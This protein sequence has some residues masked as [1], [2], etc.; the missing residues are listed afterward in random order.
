MRSY[1]VLFLALL[2]AGCGGG[3]GGSS[4]TTGSPMGDAPVSQA[5]APQDAAASSTRSFIAG[6]Y[7]DT[8]VNG[9][10]A[11][12]YRLYRAAF[13]RV[14]DAGG[15]GFQVGQIEIL[16]QPLQQVA[17]NFVASPEFASTYG[18]LTNTQF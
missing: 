4:T 3:G 15:L 11:Q 8:D 16:R 18:S 10:A 14:A 9:T 1:F 7:V 12:V 5:L 17:A 13:S 2:A 6:H